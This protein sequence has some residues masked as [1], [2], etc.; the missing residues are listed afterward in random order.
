MHHQLPTGKA[1]DHFLSQYLGYLQTQAALLSP[2]LTQGQARNCKVLRETE[3]LSHISINV[4]LTKVQVSF[5]KKEKTAE[6]SSE[7][8]AHS[9]TGHG[10]V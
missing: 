2:D 3:E 8:T 7:G 4:V 9:T 6:Q 10:T 1:K 5:L